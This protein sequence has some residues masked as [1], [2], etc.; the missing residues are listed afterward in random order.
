MRVFA[1]PNGSGKTTVFRGVAK[2]YQT[3][4]FV[5]A[6][7]IERTFQEGGS[8]SFQ[9]YGIRLRAGEWQD[10]CQ[11]SVWLQKLQESGQI[12][13]LRVHKN[14]LICRMDGP[15]SYESALTS[16][17]V[18]EALMARGKTFSVETVMSHPSKISLMQ[19]AGE[20]G[21]RTYLYFIC[22]ETPKINIARVKQRV[23]KGEH[24]V[25]VAKIRARYKRSL[26]L[27]HPAILASYRAFLFDNS[28]KEYKLLMEF[29]EGKE[30]VLREEF[31][32]EWAL[33]FGVKPIFPD[34]VD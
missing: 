14:R 1:G 3:G 26:Q 31:L 18:R 27:L 25:P 17:F 10:W 16:S 32:P 34:L 30:M 21:Y 8:L 23:A 13:K 24:D 7:E 22:T 2:S 5:N 6:D 12:Q 20:H 15:A 28:A 4:P 33:Q 19:E 29:K 9:K 11:R